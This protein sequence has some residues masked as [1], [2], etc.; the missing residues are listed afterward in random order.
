MSPYD[1]IRPKWVIGNQCPQQFG[2][3][4]WPLHGEGHIIFLCYSIIRPTVRLLLTKPDLD[5]TLISDDGLISDNHWNSTI[6]GYLPLFKIKKSQFGK[7]LFMNPALK[8]FPIS[9]WIKASHICIS[10]YYWRHCCFHTSSSA[11][12]Q[13]IL[14]T[15]FSYMFL[16]GT[17]K[18]NLWNPQK[19]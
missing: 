11:R 1:A 18:M 16:V 10:R 7:N 4:R 3:F 19:I 9:Q 5:G 13:V 2:I 14:V 15:I 6:S 17:A 12:I 8:F